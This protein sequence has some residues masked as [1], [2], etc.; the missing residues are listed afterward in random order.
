MR[1]FYE[2]KEIDR[3]AARELSVTGEAHVGH[4]G[5]SI[6]ARLAHLGGENDSY[7]EYVK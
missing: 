4:A 5:L 1:Y 2:G 3:A 6:P 7:V